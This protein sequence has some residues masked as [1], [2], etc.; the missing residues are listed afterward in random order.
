MAVDLYGNRVEDKSDWE[1]LEK[2]L[3]KVYLQVFFGIGK[4]K[5]RKRC[6]K[7]SKTV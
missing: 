7:N 3:L 1:E 4:R 5:E 6:R 2:S